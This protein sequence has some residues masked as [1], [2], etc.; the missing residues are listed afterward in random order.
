[1]SGTAPH[2]Q[3]GVFELD[4]QAGELRKHGIKLKVQRKP[5]TL[6]SLLV[7]H[8]GEVISRGDLRK[9]LWPDDT[10]V[11]FDHG[12]GIAVNKLRRVLGDT[13]DNPRFIET[14]PGR[15]FRFLVP[16]RSD[17]QS[18]RRVIA[19]LPFDNLNSD[20][21][22]D[23][24]PDGLT[25][26]LIAE[27]CRV[28]SRQLGVI[29]RTSALRYKQT[30]L[31]LRQIG[32]EL[33]VELVVQ[34]SV[35]RSGEHV[36]IAAQLTQVEDEILL[37][38]STYD[39]HVK[40]VID[41]QCDLAKQ[42]ASALKVK[43]AAEGPIVPQ[44][45]IEAYDLYLRGRHQWRTRTEQSC[46]KAIELFEAAISS[47]PK[48]SLPYV[49]VADCYIVLA[50]LGVI[51]TT[52]AY[53]KAKA[54]LN[55]ALHIN[56]GLPEAHSSLGF[57]HLDFDWNWLSAEREHL[58]AIELNPNYASAHHWYGLSLMQ[59]GS[60]GNARNEFNSAL[61]LDPLSVAIHSHRGR[62]SYLERKYENAV[63]D[64]QHAID[65]DPSFPQARYF[66]GLAYTQK[67]R[68]ADALAEFDKALE[69]SPGNVSLLAGR[70]FACRL[71]GKSA[72]CKQIVQFR[73]GYKTREGSHYL[74][75]L[76]FVGS[77]RNRDVLECLERAYENRSGWL[78]YLKTDPAFD[79]LRSDPSFQEL[80]RRIDAGQSPLLRQLDLG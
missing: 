8:A 9:A 30:K 46:Y 66:L 33:G 55:Q 65:L 19:V 74:A 42:I 79:C 59:I 11:D 16:T 48:F 22:H 64:L 31:D 78:F 77:G 56:E 4:T 32:R 60:F 15:G 27:L 29:A 21:E 67:K 58:R 25:E 13:P 50:L 76:G 1:M 5:I 35:R 17:R 39:A 80:L 44:P 68:F 40:D 63:E 36:R 18:T 12:L 45:G 73:N 20:P 34:G 26:E 53:Q 6:L 52:A 24:F 38:A 70:A 7:Q 57:I 3:F 54:A 61:R 72:R 28:D 14:L 71:A 41:V 47:D 10:V 75:S 37:W 62:L 49:G 23:Y 51:S 43:L 2:W 69:F